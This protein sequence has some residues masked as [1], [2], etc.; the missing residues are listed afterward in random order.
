MDKP[1]TKNRRR[2]EGTVVSDRMSKTRVVQVNRVRLHPKYQKRYTVTTRLKAHDE[3]N[4]Y[5]VGDRVMIEETRPL[6]REKRWRIISKIEKTAE[7]Y[8]N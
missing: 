3:K 4:A 1:K 2:L 8:N 6:S 7:T 5:K